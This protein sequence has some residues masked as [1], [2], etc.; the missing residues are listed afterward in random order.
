MFFDIAVE[1]HLQEIFTSWF[2]VL[3][4]L[5][6]QQPSMIQTLLDFLKK[7]SN[8][9]LRDD[10]FLA[11]MVVETKFLEDEI[12][13]QIFTLVVNYYNQ[14]EKWFH[15]DNLAYFYDEKIH[16]QN[17]LDSVDKT[18]YKSEDLYM[19]RNNIVEIVRLLVKNKKFSKN[20]VEYWKAQFKEWLNLDI[21][22]NKILHRNI[23]NSLTVVVKDDFEYIKSLYF[24]F[25]T[26][27]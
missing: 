23:I 4:F 12:R 3:P 6:E 16:Y 14:H 21:M 15:I 24:I 20:Q 19:R 8:K 13:T 18:Q 9:A 10:Y 25:E 1:P 11:L 17:L 27:N 22:S 26:G 2:Y 5:L 7:N